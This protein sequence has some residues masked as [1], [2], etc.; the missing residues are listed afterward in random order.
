MLRALVEFTL[1]L[2]KLM[3]NSCKADFI[4]L[5]IYIGDL[6]YKTRNIPN[7]YFEALLR[8]P[9]LVQKIRDLRELIIPPSKPSSL[10]GVEVAYIKHT[11]HKPFSY[12]GE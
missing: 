2:T 4:F 6:N 3:L 1:K 7:W 5:K 11:T 8:F 9:L 12:T 10:P